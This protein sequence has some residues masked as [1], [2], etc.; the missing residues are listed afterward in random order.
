[1]SNFE[2]IN[3]ASQIIK[4]T[5]NNLLNNEEELYKYRISICKDKCG[6]Y[7]PTGI[8]GQECN[9]KIYWNPD[10]NQKSDIPKMGFYKGCGCALNSATRAKDH[11]CPINRW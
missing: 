5:I 8:F 2:L 4:G 10:T 1:M 11:T 3:Q 7:N 9:S 6:L